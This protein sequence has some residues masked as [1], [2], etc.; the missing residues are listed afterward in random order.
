LLLLSDKATDIYGKNGVAKKWRR[1]EHCQ[2]RDYSI[3]TSRKSGGARFVLNDGEYDPH[4]CID[5][6][7]N[8]RWGKKACNGV[9]VVPITNPPLV[10]FQDD[11]NIPAWNPLYTGVVDADTVEWH[12]STRSPW[13]RWPD[14]SIPE[15]V[16]QRERDIITGKQGWWKGKV[17]ATSMV[18]YALQFK[19]P[20]GV[21]AAYR[22]SLD[23]TD[24]IFYSTCYFSERSRV[25][26]NDLA[27]VNAALTGGD[28]GGFN[29]KE[30]KFTWAFGENQCM[31]C[32]DA[33]HALRNNIKYK[34][35]ES[36][37]K[38]PR[39]MAD[40]HNNVLL[41]NATWFDIHRECKYCERDVQ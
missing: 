16:A 5:W 9:N 35:G 20:T 18:C 33:N 24:S 29:S 30:V 26:S 32:E 12:G 22:T 8:N 39:A 28:A 25:F 23:P 3:G 7:V 21:G 11:I 4:P 15:N 2:F 40:D 34:K 19:E 13:L 6:C 27:L 10:R 17:N 1:V 38:S 37:Q 36:L 31:T 41:L 14:G